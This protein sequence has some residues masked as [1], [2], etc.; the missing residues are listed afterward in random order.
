MHLWQEVVQRLFKE[1]DQEEEQKQNGDPETRSDKVLDQAATVRDLIFTH[2]LNHWEKMSL[3]LTPYLWMFHHENVFWSLPTQTECHSD[4]KGGP[5][6]YEDNKEELRNT[7]GQPFQVPHRESVIFF[8]TGKKILRP[9]GVWEQEG[10]EPLGQH[11]ASSAAQGMVPA[12][13]D[14]PFGSETL[15]VSTNFSDM[16]S[17]TNPSVLSQPTGTTETISSNTLH[18]NSLQLIVILQSTVLLFPLL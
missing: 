11:G 4:Q 13:T 10:P 2:S 9:A 18:R 3:T 7:V 1:T 5:G 14:R 15:P 17:Q 16:T 8:S 12:Q 6:N